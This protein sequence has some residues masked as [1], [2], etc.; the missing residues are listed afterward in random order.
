MMK[1]SLVVVAVTVY[2][3][4]CGSKPANPIPPPPLCV[5]YDT[6]EVLFSYGPAVTREQTI[7]DLTRRI[8]RY[9][10]EYQRD[11]ETPTSKG[12][13]RADVDTVLTLRIDTLEGV[14]VS[15]LIPFT[16]R[17][18]ASEARLRYYVTM[19]APGSS[20]LLLDSNDDRQ[21]E[22]LD[23]LARKV[24]KKVHGWSARHY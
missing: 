7:T 13:C 2:L 24:A 14:A 16:A 10:T 18:D 8:D 9:L 11:D 17:V 20:N 19:K 15:K 3:A 21:Y 6:A 12:P 23:D 22:S 1:H 5:Q 4:A